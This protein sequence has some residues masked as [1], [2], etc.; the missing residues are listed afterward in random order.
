MVL[1]SRVL[2]FRGSG[3]RVITTH[4]KLAPPK[5]CIDLANGGNESLW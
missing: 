2:G 5:P 1:G 3:G 4:I